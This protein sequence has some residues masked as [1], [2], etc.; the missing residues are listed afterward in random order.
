[1]P[2]A[3][4][5]PESSSPKMYEA[6]SESKIHH[7]LNKQVSQSTL[8]VVIPADDMEHLILYSVRG[9]IYNRFD[10]KSVSL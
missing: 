10:R 9:S 7:V 2:I 4:H 1:M 6:N 8:Q 3:Y 5:S